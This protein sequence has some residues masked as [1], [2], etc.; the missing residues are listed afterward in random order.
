MKK[1]PSILIIYT[2]GTIGMAQDPV[3]G[4]LLPVNFSE[5]SKQ[6]PELIRFDLNIETVTFSP[7][8]DSSEVDTGIWI[9]MAATIKE[10][11]GEYDGF[12]ILH[13][14]DTMSYSA[15]A[16]SFLLEGL[17]K[18]VI[19][20]GSQLPIGMLRT[21]GRENLISS[22]EIAAAR[23]NGLPVVPEVCIFFQNKLFRGN[24]TTK[25]NVENF[26]AFHSDNYPALAETG[27]NIM[28][29]RSAIMNPEVTRQLKVHSGMN[30][31]VVILKIFPG[32]TEKLINTIYNIDGLRGVIMET[33]GA[34]NAPTASW[35]ISGIEKAVKKGI[36]VLNVTQCAT[37]SVDMN[38]YQ[39]GKR[40]LE[41]GVISGH[42]IT[43]E[44]AVTKLMFILAQT[45]EEKK[46]RTL[47]NRSLRGE[48]N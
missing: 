36:T 17:G 30:T 28:Y 42:D 38:Q 27:I 6:L 16:L 18:P 9:R 45:A 26:N 2:G 5:I 10:V 15:S 4:N 33:Y 22:I 46:I 24:R 37:G 11:Y 8:L 12:V 44:A 31:D 40:L 3:T 29:N 43:T 41:A 23:E 14:T 39:T 21:D 35:F 19:F 20:T 1:K 25:H 7:P 13:G 32:I 47:I 34:G 48:I